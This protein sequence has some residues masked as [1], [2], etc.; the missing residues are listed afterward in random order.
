MIDKKDI[1]NIIIVGVIL[2]LLDF[3][4]LYFNQDWYKRETY[5]SQKS[6]LKLKI[7]GVIG[8]YLAQT[9]GLYIFILRN[10]L[11]LIYSLLYGLIIYGNYIGTNYATITIFDEKLAIFDLIKGGTIMT[12]TS[13]IYY[14]LK[15]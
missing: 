12:M 9:L 2:F 15:F 5:K 10:K 1:K 4:Y 11:P 7:I 6:E 13:Y 14:K 3:T 8:R